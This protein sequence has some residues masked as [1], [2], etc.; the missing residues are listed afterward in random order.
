MVEKYGLYV[1]A[2]SAVIGIIGYLWLMVRAFKVRVLW[3][4]ALLL[5]PPLALWFIVAHFRKAWGPVLVLLLAGVLAAIPYGINYYERHFVPLKPYEQ[6]VDG[7]LRITL[8][9]LKDFDYGSLRERREVVV[10]QMANEDVDDQT[11]EHLKG[12]DRLRKLDLSGTRITDEGLA[13]VAELPRLQELYVA[14]TKI[15]DKG[16][17]KHLAPKETLL[18]LDL[19]G[20]KVNGKTMRAWKKL[21]PLEREYVD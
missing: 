17:Q 10:L 7:E 19:T 5:V 21:K 9:G 3:G 4:V 6:I 18:K 11:L 12:M 2:L 8:T 15:T 20:T 16:F 1:L 13:L 14:R